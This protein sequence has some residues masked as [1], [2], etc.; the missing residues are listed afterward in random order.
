MDEFR[1][2]TDVGESHRSKGSPGHMESADQAVGRCT[3]AMP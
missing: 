2:S 1:Q 3:C